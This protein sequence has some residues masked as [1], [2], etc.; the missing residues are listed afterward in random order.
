MFSLRTVRRCRKKR[1]RFGRILPV[2]WLVRAWAR[3]NFPFPVRRNFLDAIRF[4]LIFGIAVPN[5]SSFSIN[6][7]SHYQRA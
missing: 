7:N 6:L 5:F 4:V 3:L 2:L 1:F